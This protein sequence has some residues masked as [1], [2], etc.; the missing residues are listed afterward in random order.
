MKL[1]KG[2][3]MVAAVLAVIGLYC[4][5]AFDTTLAKAGLPGNFHNCYENGFGAVT[6]CGPLSPGHNADICQ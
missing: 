1:T 2:W 3:I 4:L 5:G 6:C